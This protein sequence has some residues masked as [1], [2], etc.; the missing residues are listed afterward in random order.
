MGILTKLLGGA[1]GCR[2]AMRESYERH[3]R[4]AKQGKVAALGSPHSFGL[5]GA[6]GSRYRFSLRRIVEVEMWSELVPFLL[7]SESEAVE[8]LAEYV[9]YQ[10]Q[11]LHARVTWLKNLINS[12]LSAN[13][14]NPLITAAILA[15]EKQVAWCS[16]L[17]PATIDLLESAVERHKGG[18]S[19]ADRDKLGL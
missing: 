10:E 8:A 9:V 18:I 7:M 3:L 11:P 16:L 14:N 5:Y 19:E 1:D 17:E 6:L 15:L 2:E 12:S 13:P 4:L